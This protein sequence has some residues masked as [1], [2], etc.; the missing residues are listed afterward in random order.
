MDGTVYSVDSVMFQIIE[1]KLEM[2]NVY[3]RGRVPTSGWSNGRLTPYVYISPPESG[4]WDFGFIATAPSGI[5]LQVITNI[6]SAIFAAPK[7]PWCKG[8][9]VH[10]ATNEI[11]STTS[12]DALTPNRMTLFGGG[13]TPWPWGERGSTNVAGN[14]VPF[15]WADEPWPWVA[16][17]KK[18]V[19]TLNTPDSKH[20]NNTIN[21]LIGKP[22]R[23]YHEGDPITMDFRA[24]RVNI[25]LSRAGNTIVDIHLG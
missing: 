13:D 15:P 22:V 18:Y 2:I 24:D 3:A 20:L 23:V 25:V 6:E 5:A 19:A 10:A 1:G 14:W 8:I 21:S 12:H 9:R 4:I 11:E 7:P 17:V 16:D